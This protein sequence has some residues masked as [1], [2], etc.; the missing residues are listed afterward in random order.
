MRG[1]SRCAKS[2]WLGSVHY[3]WEGERGVRGGADG[4]VTASSSHRK[5]PLPLPSTALPVLLDGLTDDERRA[6]GEE[7]NI[8][9]VPAAFA[10]VR[11]AR[12]PRPT[13]RPA[14]LAHLL[15]CL[16]AAVLCNGDALAAVGAWGRAHRALLAWPFPRHRVHTPSGSL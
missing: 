14:L 7:Q 10:A 4:V 1:A 13:L 5:E 16:V 6:L 2:K 11:D 3:L 9:S 12:A 8:V 15:T